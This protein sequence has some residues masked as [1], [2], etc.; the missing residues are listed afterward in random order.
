LAV[1][2]K[3]SASTQNQALNALVFFFREGLGKELGQLGEFTPAKRPR[4]IPVVPLFVCFVAFCEQ[5]LGL[6]VSRVIARSGAECNTLRELFTI[7]VSRRERINGLI[8]ATNPA[9]P[10]ARLSL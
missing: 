7:L 6:P 3:L 1:L 9:P 10:T 8:L 4:K 2:A 5:P